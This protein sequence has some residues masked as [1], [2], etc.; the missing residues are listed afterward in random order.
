MSLHFFRVSKFAVVLM[1]LGFLIANSNAETRSLEQEI[2]GR[3]FELVATD[4][5][6]VFG[7]EDKVVADLISLRDLESPPYVSTRAEKL[8]LGFSNREDVR[9]ILRQDV[10][11]EKSLGLCSVILSNITSIP[12]EAFR[13][14]LANSALS[15]I[16]TSSGQKVLPSR[17]NR[18]KSIL[19]SSTDKKV[20]ALV[21]Q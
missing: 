12:D 6:V 9:A 11:D 14:E 2:K 16:S 10:V 3:H 7:G 8:L 1:G 20:K 5:S 4:L 19:N 17:M 15:S 13:M 18:V 21:N